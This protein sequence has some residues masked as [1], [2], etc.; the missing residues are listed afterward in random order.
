MFR[1]FRAPVFGMMLFLGLLGCGGCAQRISRNEPESHQPRG[2]VRNR[3]FSAPEEL[4]DQSP[5]PRI[6]RLERTLEW[7]PKKLG[8]GERMASRDE[9]PEETLA[10]LREY[11]QEQGLGDVRIVIDEYSP[12]RHWQRLR[13]GRAVSA[14]WRYTGGTLGWAKAS[15]LPSR[16]LDQNYY[17]PASNTLY[18]NSN[19]PFELIAEAAYARQ[20]RDKDWR[21]TRL[22][23]RSI[24][25]VNQFALID[26][27]REALS[28]TQDQELWELEQQGYRRVYTQSCMVPLLVAGSFLPWYAA[29]VLGVAGHSAGNYLAQRKIEE[30]EPERRATAAVQESGAASAESAIRPASLGS[31]EPARLDRI[32]IDFEGEGSQMTP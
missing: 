28:Y 14:G 9:I 6:D 21:G 24:D 20:L 8:F 7:L 3:Q 16:A 29:P 19:D 11:M 13:E 27:S 22:T 30:L 23:V 4:V 17:D 10:H 2:L 32:E 12:R 5:H 1:P 25:I 31:L 15:I 18:I 26:A